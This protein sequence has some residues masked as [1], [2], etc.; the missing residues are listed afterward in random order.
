MIQ[1]TG[2]IFYGGPHATDLVVRAMSFS[3]ELSAPFTYNLEVAS[4]KKDLDPKKFLGQPVTVKI[5]VEGGEPRFFSGWVS[6]FYTLGA[7]LENTVYRMVLRPWL[8]FLQNSA[9][10]QIS[11]STNREIRRDPLHAQRRPAIGNNEEGEFSR[12]VRVSQV[13][14]GQDRI[15]AC[16]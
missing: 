14:A 4:D 10:C 9:D 2:P 16:A 6:E 1:S 7:V 8:A 3:E 11:S 5:A 13:W 12:W 15:H